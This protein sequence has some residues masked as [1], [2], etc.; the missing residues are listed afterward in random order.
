MMNYTT[1]ILARQR[2]RKKKKKS[3]AV[4]PTPGTYIISA[5][6]EDEWGKNKTSEKL[7]GQCI[8]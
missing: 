8:S 3:S 4:R 5:W 6:R 1:V 7:G 2:E